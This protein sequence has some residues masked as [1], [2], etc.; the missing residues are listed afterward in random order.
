MIL[1]QRAAGTPKVQSLTFFMM[2]LYNNSQQQMPLTFNGQTLRIG[3][4]CCHVIE[5]RS[6]GPLSQF[7]ANRAFQIINCYRSQILLYSSGLSGYWDSKLQYIHSCI[8]RSTIY[9]VPLLQLLWK[10]TDATTWLFTTLNVTK[11]YNKTSHT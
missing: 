11:K 7:R 6:N 9:L 4:G 3:V 5:G 8:P 10:I 2:Q 1:D